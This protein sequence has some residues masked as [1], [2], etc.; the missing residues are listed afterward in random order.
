MFKQL[1]KMEVKGGNERMHG[2]V[3]P[4]DS[5]LGE[6]HDALCIMKAHVIE[7]MEAQQKKD[8]AMLRKEAKPEAT[9][10]VLQPEIV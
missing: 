9:Y 7:Q 5:P 8:V 3:C 2:Y 4:I 6:I 1:A 10:D